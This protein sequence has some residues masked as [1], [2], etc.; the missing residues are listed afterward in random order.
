MAAPCWFLLGEGGGECTL[1][2]CA[3]VAE[4][5]CERCL[6]KKCDCSTL[7]ATRSAVG[8]PAARVSVVL[9]RELLWLRMTRAMMM[10]M[11]KI[12]MVR[13]EMKLSLIHI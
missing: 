1:I 7:A 5:S 10:M 8:L 2:H 11:K 4:F 9:L 13:M 6:C 12:M 3:V